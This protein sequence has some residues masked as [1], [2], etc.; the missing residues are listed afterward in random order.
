MFIRKA[1]FGGW[2]TFRRR[3]QFPRKPE[4]FWS[5]AALS[6]SKDL[7]LLSALSLPSR[8]QEVNVVALFMLQELILR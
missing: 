1:D 2:F 7:S 3:G 4:K 8:R 6:P 5:R